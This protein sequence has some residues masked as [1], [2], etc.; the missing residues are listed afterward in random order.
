MCSVGNILCSF[1][2]VFIP[3]Q[4]NWKGRRT[5][6]QT[7]RILFVFDSGRSKRQ[8]TLFSY[9]A[10][11]FVPPSF[12]I[13]CSL[14]VLF[15]HKSF[16]TKMRRRLESPHVDSRLLFFMKL[17]PFICTHSLY[18]SSVLCF[19]GVRLSSNFNFVFRQVTV[20]TDTLKRF[21]SVVTF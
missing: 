6:D 12:L 2:R 15:F 5:C 21:C 19:S 4:R 11:F 18:D 14:V 8:I 7:G 13:N 16:L 10:S 3:R 20:T 1:L 17:K 9:R